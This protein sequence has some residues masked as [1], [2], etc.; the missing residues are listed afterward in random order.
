MPNGQLT[1]I[2]PAAGTFTIPVQVTD[3]AQGSITRTLT[4]QVVA[5]LTVTAPATVTITS[6]STFTLTPSASQ[7]APPYTYSISAGMLPPGLTLS[8]T[9]VISGTPTATGTF[10]FTIQ[11]TDGTGTIVQTVVTVVVSAP[12]LTI[13]TA[14]TLPAGTAGT[15]YLQ[16][17]QALNGTGTLTWSLA[18]GTLP[19][20]LSV[21][22]SGV[23]SGTP[24]QGGT[25]SFTVQVTDGGGATATQTFVVVI[26]APAQ[27]PAV[28]AS[29]SAT[30]SAGDQPMVTIMLAAP[31]PLPIQVTATLQ[32]T[33]NPGN[34]TDLLFANGSRTTQFTI[35]ANVT[36]V[37]LPFQ[38]GTLAGSILIQF[39]LQ[40]GGADVTP[41]PAP[42]VTTQIA[43]AAPVLRSVS[44]SLI[45]G[46]FQLT[47]VGVST[48]RDMKTIAIHFTAA[49]G[50]TLQSTDA[51]LDVSSVFAQ[52][53][54]NPS[55][56]ATGSQFSLTLPVTVGGDVASI[57]SVSV[58]MTN[59]VGASSSTSATIQ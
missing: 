42:S 19:P 26:A 36:Q 13:M 48:T 23:L 32:L 54:Q 31:Y 20:G 10:T 40:A 55:S 7:G 14:G 17:F 33:P 49:N 18:G 12:A 11:V 22:P 9:G 1:A 58:V 45:N 4:V 38:S 34:D 27:V 3:A 44:A 24:T 39:R 53:Y 29:L 56:L 5:P 8:T 30:V 16:G 46:G 52:W 2:F 6:G 35:P 41:N 57:A 28:T 43:A 37:T 25:F 51:S 50:S 59:S 21:S 47:I 15:A